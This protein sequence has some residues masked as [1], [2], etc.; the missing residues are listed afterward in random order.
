MILLACISSSCYFLIAGQISLVQ[1]SSSVILFTR[2]ETSQ[3]NHGNGGMKQNVRDR[4]SS[5]FLFIFLL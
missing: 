1:V 5:S 2:S 4:E 3:T